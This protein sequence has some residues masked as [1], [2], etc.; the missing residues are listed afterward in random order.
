MFQQMQGSSNASKRSKTTATVHSPCPGLTSNNHSL[1]ASYLSR[2]SAEGGGGWSD[3]VIAMERFGKAF[4][5]LKDIQQQE[6]RQMQF[7]EH[8]WQNHHKDGRIYATDCKRTVTLT[9]PDGGI[10]PCP[11]CFALLKLNGFQSVLKKSTPTDSNYK[12]TNKRWRNPI[13]G[14]I[15]ARIQGVRE[16]M[17]SA[18]RNII[19]SIPNSY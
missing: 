13:L 2:S 11:P 14:N 15:Y 1:I 16:I 6:V 3:G 8:K 17:E 4:S 5:E 9:T 12:Y 18:V 10:L 19:I 7:H